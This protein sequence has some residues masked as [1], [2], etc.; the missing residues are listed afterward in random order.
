M[1]ELLYVCLA[2]R[3]YKHSPDMLAKIL[4]ELGNEAA[5]QLLQ[6][7]DLCC[8]LE[9]FLVEVGGL[10]FPARLTSTHVLKCGDMYS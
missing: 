2:K 4:N 8:P 9:S 1:Q 3:F 10:I 5:V 7:D 6:R